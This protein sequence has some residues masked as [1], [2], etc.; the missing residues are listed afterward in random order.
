M[1]G[2]FK[3][4]HFHAV[5]NQV[6]DIEA[7]L[8][9]AARKLTAAEEAAAE[10]RRQKT[11]ILTHQVAVLSDCASGPNSKLKW[12]AHTPCLLLLLRRHNMMA[13]GIVQRAALTVVLCRPLDHKPEGIL[14]LKTHCC[15][16]TK[17]RCRHLLRS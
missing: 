3:R 10:A 11:D 8:G 7:E 6:T 2:V 4:A 9:A 12:A 15:A 14:K 5:S 13:L 1:S 17:M 16:F